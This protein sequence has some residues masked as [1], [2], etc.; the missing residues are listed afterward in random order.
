MKITNCIYA[1]RKISKQNRL[2]GTVHGSNGDETLCGKELNYTWYLL[3]NGNNH[4]LT[5]K[6]CIQL[7]GAVIDL[8]HA[9][10]A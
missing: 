4:K 9:G 1:T 10:K 3:S 7:D 2:Y 8:A 5:C 6:R